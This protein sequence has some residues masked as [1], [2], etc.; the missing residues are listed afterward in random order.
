MARGGLQGAEVAYRAQ[1]WPTGGRDDLSRPEVTCRVQR[2]PI[3]AEVVCRG[4]RWPMGA[5]ITCRGRG[6]LQGAEVAYRGQGKPVGGRGG[7][8]GQ[9]WSVGGKGGL[10]GAEITCRGQRW[11]IGCR[12]G[13]QRAEVVCIE[14][15]KGRIVCR[16]G[17]QAQVVQR[18]QK[19]P[20]V[21]YCYTILK[22]LQKDI[23]SKVRERE[24]ARFL[25]RCVIP[26]LIFLWKVFTF[27]SQNFTKS[28]TATTKRI[29]THLALHQD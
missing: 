26:T 11:P 29:Q 2:W 5:E 21:L 4:Q 9:R 18:R 7:L 27:H 24:S 28:S 23:R 10:Y 15:R 17:L 3:G 12:D 16:G 25:Q 14:S 19:C 13:V 20:V 8:Q 1:R 22:A 6:G